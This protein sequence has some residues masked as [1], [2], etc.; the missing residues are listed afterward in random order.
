[1]LYKQSITKKSKIL[2]T[3]LLVQAAIS[4]IAVYEL[5]KVQTFTQMQGEHSA[6]MNEAL[7][8]S[9]QL[10]APNSNS[11]VKRLLFNSSH[12]IQED[13][14]QNLIHKARKIVVTCLD[15]VNGA[16]I[17]TFRMIGFGKAIDLCREDLVDADRALKILG[18]ISTTNDDESYSKEL[19][20]LRIIVSKMSSDSLIFAELMPDLASFVKTTVF[21]VVPFLSIIAA[22]FLY[23]VLSNT[24]KKLLNLSEKMNYIRKTNDLSVRIFLDPIESEN[25]NDEVV[26]V[27]EDFNIMMQQ[28]DSVVSNITQMSTKLFEATTPL[29]DASQTSQQKMIEQNSAADEI[30][31][32]MTGF[33]GVIN[34]IAAN[35][36]NTSE[37]ANK[38]FAQSESGRLTIRDAKKSVEKL[39]ESSSTMQKKVLSLD[40]NATQ[41]TSITDVINAISDQTNLLALNAAIEAARAGVQGR[42]FAVVADEVRALALRTQEDTE[43]I[44][45]M[46]ASLQSETNLTV[47]LISSNGEYVDSLMSEMNLADETLTGIADSTERIKDMNMQI[48]TATEEQIYVVE[49]IQS[50]VRGMKSLSNETTDAVSEVLNSFEQI[51]SVIENMNSTVDRFKVSKNER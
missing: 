19:Q 5:A 24:R 9:N 30:V 20:S 27:C 2:L 7:N 44:R 14:L 21:V 15:M 10:F 51:S 29:Y 46:I 35:T 17:F 8:R 4:I 3:I 39:S 38:G 12:V 36:N 13:G 34:E 11:E 16:E 25:T 22:V 6:A 47:T 32:L 23:L 18:N 45:T 26:L 37:S 31:G 43:K 1:M 28:F 40:S 48:A 50:S 49:Q 33:V 41:I 42:G